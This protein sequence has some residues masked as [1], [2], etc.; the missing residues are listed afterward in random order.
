MHILWTEFDILRV[1]KSQIVKDLLSETVENSR[2]K[3]RI[4]TREF[5]SDDMDHDEM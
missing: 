4:G 2:K 3:N 1:K 5:I